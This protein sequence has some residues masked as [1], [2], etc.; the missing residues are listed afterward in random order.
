MRGSHTPSAAIVALIAC[1]GAVGAISA[2][3]MA[4]SAPSVASAPAAGARGR[5]AGMAALLD[6][7][8]EAA[9][10]ARF[11]KALPFRKAAVSIMAAARYD[12]FGEGFRGVMIGDDGWLFSSEEFEAD[13]GYAEEDFGRLVA[14]V[15]D[16]LAA[17]GLTLAVAVVPSKSRIMAERLGTRRMP[18][19]LE[20]RYAA[21]IEVLRGLSV[22]AADLESALGATRD[23]GQ[24][25][26]LRTDTHWSIDGAKAAANEAART[27][28]EALPG[29]E[30]AAVST[31]MTGEAEREGDLLS[32]LPE[33]GASARPLPPPDRVGVYET[34][35]D[36]GAGLFGA[37]TIPVALVGTSYSAEPDFHF[38]GFLK[39]A[40]SAD[41]LNLSSEGEGPFVPMERALSGTALADSGVRVVLWE[42]PERYV[43]MGRIIAP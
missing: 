40:L 23:R 27:I 16:D 18:P 7:E 29:L 5:G 3:R 28:L 37:Q 13:L 34:V 20:P 8:A 42:I 30:T 22:P 1:T 26:F 39:E 43:P 31:A 12:L 24:A 32:Y 25:P 9:F 15:R 17:R 41:V 19:S 14:R 4:E 6:G 33:R 2:I 21:M 38:E 11:E 10:Q 35:V 36:S